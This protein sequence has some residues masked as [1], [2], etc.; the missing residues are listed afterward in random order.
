MRAG[1]DIFE[2]GLPQRN[3]TNID[4]RNQYIKDKNKNADTIRPTCA[5]ITFKHPLGAYLARKARKSP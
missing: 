5:F 4:K 3:K 2:E 1:G